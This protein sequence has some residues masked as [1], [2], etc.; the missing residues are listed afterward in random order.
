M[1][2]SM[3]NSK[4]AIFTTFLFSLGRPWGN[5]AK[6]CINEKTIQCLPNPSQHVTT[7]CFKTKFTLLLFVISY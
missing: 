4:I 6:R 3:R 1:I 5:H 2:K 7:L